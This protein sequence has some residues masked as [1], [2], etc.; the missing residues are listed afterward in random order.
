MAGGGQLLVP[1][2]L[3]ATNDK[4]SLLL[5]NLVADLTPR[6]GIRKLLKAYPVSDES[7]RN[8]FRA[9]ILGEV[10]LTRE[11]LN[12]ELQAISDVIRVLRGQPKS[13]YGAEQLA[14]ELEACEDNH[15]EQIKAPNRCG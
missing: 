4:L 13:S 3:K 11:Q 10:V 9:V 6:D 8:R 14:R 1:S 12:E 15:A 5:N 7:R 2:D